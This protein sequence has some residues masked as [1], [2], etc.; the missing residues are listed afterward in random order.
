[1]AKKNRLSKYKRNRDKNY[2]DNGENEMIK[3]EMLEE[4]D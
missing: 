3:I 2:K 4:T 1:M